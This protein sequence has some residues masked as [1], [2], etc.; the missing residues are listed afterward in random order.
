MPQEKRQKRHHRHALYL[1]SPKSLRRSSS[2]S[3]P[4]SSPSHH[5]PLYH[6]KQHFK[7]DKPSPTNSAEQ[8]M[9]PHL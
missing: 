7:P 6:Q 9:N 2:R 3:L 8:E 5:Q 1:Q 4:P